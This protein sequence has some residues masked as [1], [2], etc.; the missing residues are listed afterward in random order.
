M[1]YALLSAT[2]AQGPGNGIAKTTYAASNPFPGLAFNLKYFPTTAAIDSCSGNYCA[3]G[4][5][6]PDGEKA[7]GRAQLVNS[8]SL[9]TER[10]CA[11]YTSASGSTSDSVTTSMTAPTSLG[12]DCSYVSSSKYSSASLMH[13]V[14]APTA[15]T[16]CKACA[17]TDGCA[18]AT[19]WSG[20]DSLSGHWDTTQPA[21]RRLQPEPYMGEG[22]G[23]HLVDVKSSSTSGG[24]DAATL[25]SHFASRTGDFSKYDAFMDFSVQ[26][27]TPELSYYAKLF[28]KDGVKTLSASWSPTGSSDTWYSLFLLVPKSQMIIEL[29]GNEA[30]GTNAIAATLEPRVSPRNVALYKD[31][32]ADAVHML[33]ATSVSRATT[34]MTAVHKFYTDVLQATLVDSADVSGASRRCYKWG[35]AKSDVCFVQRTDSSNYPFTVKAMEQMLWGVHAKNLVE[36]TD[37]DKYN[38]NHFAADLQISGDYIVTYMDAHNPYP[39]ST[40][41]WWGYACDQSYL[42]D[43][44]GWTIQTDL[45]FTSSYPGCT[46]SKAKATKK[47]AAPA[48][49]KA[50][51]CPGGQLTKCL[52]LCPSAPKT[53]FKAC[54]ES[55]TTRC[56][57][58]IAAYEAGEV[59]AYRQ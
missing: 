18:K 59:E 51:T 27:F 25:E 11:L 46:E 44:T 55:C 5:F 14:F 9:Y 31:T 17:A 57:A 13:V 16:C 49:R 32:S 28:A 35:T 53:A 58:E 29:V 43:P 10:N 15:D 7:Q 56:A 38:D 21:G 6:S 34:N 48:A 42:I 3:S 22:F 41:S 23:L 8:A 12:S 47:V 1:I 52:E 19:F 33:Y 36:P 54:V 45:S 40:S 24:I 2:V 30:P 20:S 37:G 26:L 50:S 4:S 39:L